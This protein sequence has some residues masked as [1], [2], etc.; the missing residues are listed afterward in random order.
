[1]K[2]FGMCVIC[3]VSSVSVWAASNC[4]SR[5][6]KN[7]DKTTA[8]KINYCL[9]EDTTPVAEEKETEIIWS[10]TY[11]VQY[12]KPKNKQAKAKTQPETKNVKVYKS[13][14]VAMTYTDRNT[15]PSFR[16]DTLPSLND[17]QANE[18]ALEALRANPTAKNAKQQKPAVKKKAAKPARQVKAENA[19]TAQQQAQQQ[20]AQALQNDPL[21]TNPTDNGTVPNEFL[22]DSIMGPSGFGYNATDPAFQQ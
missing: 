17:N 8:E 7:L 13:G 4:V 22:D 18:A 5:V 15:Y 12:P 3:L 19:A 21:A 9:T 11:S 6:D 10:D 14:P 20:Q 1:M 16:N 2:S